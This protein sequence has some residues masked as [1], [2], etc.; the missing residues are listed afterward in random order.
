ML[1][2][3][4]ENKVIIVRVDYPSHFETGQRSDVTLVP[5]EIVRGRSFI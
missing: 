5:M 3:H 2:L 4:L 1:W